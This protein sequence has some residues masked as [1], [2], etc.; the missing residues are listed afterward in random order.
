MIRN[1]TTIRLNC[2]PFVNKTD[3]DFLKGVSNRALLRAHPEPDLIQLFDK[4]GQLKINDLRE[5]LRKNRGNVMYCNI[6][7]FFYTLIYF[8]CCFRG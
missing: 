2:S 4:S 8:C 7:L 3:Y 1:S 6:K 5:Q